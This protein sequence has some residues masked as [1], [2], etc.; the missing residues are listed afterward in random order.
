MVDDALSL[1]SDSA[2]PSL[3][4]QAY[5]LYMGRVIA[6]SRDL[7]ALLS[8][9]AVL[10]VADH[11][12]ARFTVELAAASPLMMGSMSLSVSTIN[13]LKKL[14]KS[15]DMLSR[16]LCDTNPSSGGGG[17]GTVISWDDI[18]V[19]VRWI[20]KAVNDLR[21]S[22]KQSVVTENEV[23]SYLKICTWA[24][25]ELTKF[26][27]ALSEYWNRPVL[28]NMSTISSSSSK[29]RLWKEGGHAAVPPREDEWLLLQRLRA[30]VNPFKRNLPGFV[31]TVVE[32]VDVLS[33]GGV[34][35]TCS[36]RK[37]WLC[38]YSTFYWMHT[39][40]SSSTASVSSKV[41][42]EALMV[43][44]QGEF[45][46]LNITTPTTKDVETNSSE[47]DT[48]GEA[49]YPLLAD[50]DAGLRVR[51]EWAQA[52]D[53]SCSLLVEPSV[54]ASMLTIS[55]LL[56]GILVNHSNRMLSTTV[57]GKGKGKESLR[58]LDSYVS[59]DELQRLSSLLASLISM[60][61]R[62]TFFDVSGFR[63]MQTLLWSIEAVLALRIEQNS[64]VL[65]VK[66]G[67]KGVRNG[68]KEVEV[69]NEK[70]LYD[71]EESLMSLARVFTVQFDVRL[72]TLLYHNLV[73]MSLLYI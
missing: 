51:Q 5:A 50:K 52:G 55:N 19:S 67:K 66:K 25:F 28:L 12:M 30:V 34:D 9:Y 45:D 21:A 61:I 1:S 4:A 14:T 13:S 23:L 20:K 72:G 33:G 27:R 47:S 22:V 39:N 36:L 48:Y 54:I 49:D 29:L 63:E 17:K 69:D 2:M 64:S 37:E 42:V 35:R 68:K 65:V 3:Y 18:I 46:R 43:A 71:A 11:V 58:N 7:Q 24:H 15:R 59:S 10:L 73:G 44:L 53:L 6:D 26:D 8:V 56:A 57:E 62:Y 31:D 38:L 40:E 16:V 70:A 60:G 41:N 32:G